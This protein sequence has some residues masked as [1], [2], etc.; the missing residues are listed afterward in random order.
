[1]DTK[2]VKVY[3]DVDPDINV[4]ELDLPEVVEIPESIDDI[5]DYLSDEYG[6]CV[7]SYIVD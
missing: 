2:K 3:W 1:M 4:E 6:Y 5:A 7:T